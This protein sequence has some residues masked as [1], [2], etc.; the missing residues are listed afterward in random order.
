MFSLVVIQVLASDWLETSVLCHV[1]ISTG[2]LTWQLVSLR[3]RSPG[4]KGGGRISR[5]EVTVFL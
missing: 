2:L 3:V 5:N 1:G 4:G